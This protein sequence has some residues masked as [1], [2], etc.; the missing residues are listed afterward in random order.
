MVQDGDLA[1]SQIDEISDALDDVVSGRIVFGHHHLNLTV[2]ADKPEQLRKNLSAAQAELA[3]SGIVVAREDLA[4][5]AAFWAQLPANK[6]P[7]LLQ[8]LLI[9]KISL[10]LLTLNE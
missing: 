1:T 7:F 2:F 9:Q 3:D 10:I 6:R 4:L 8:R 5:S